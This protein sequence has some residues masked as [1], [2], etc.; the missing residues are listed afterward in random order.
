MLTPAAVEKVFARIRRRL[1]WSDQGRAQRP[2]LHHCRHT[3]TV[4]RLLR[5]Y[6][7]GAIASQ[8]F[9]GLAQQQQE[10]AS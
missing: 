1:G 9:E 10:S 4:R 6:D 3:F 7:E 5:W 2:R 8:R